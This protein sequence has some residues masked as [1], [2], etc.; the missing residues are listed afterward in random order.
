MTNPIVP[1]AV[2]YADPGN[3]QAEPSPVVGNQA[4]AGAPAGLLAPTQPVLSGDDAQKLNQVDLDYAKQLEAA[5][6]IAG[7]HIANPRIGPDGSSR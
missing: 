4:V 2:S 3:T 1:Q 7:H 6:D 5:V